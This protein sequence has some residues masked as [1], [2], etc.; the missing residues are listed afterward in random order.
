MAIMLRK[1]PREELGF[2]SEIISA[3]G[4]ATPPCV[5]KDLAED[6]SEFVTTI[7]MQVRTIVIALFL[8]KFC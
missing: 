5:S 7:V 6:C 3:V 8:I 1:M 2:D 4:Y